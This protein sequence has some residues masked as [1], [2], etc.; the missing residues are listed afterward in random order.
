MSDLIRLAKDL[1][2]PLVGTN[3]LHYTHAHDAKSHAALLCVQSGS[4]LNDPNRFKFDAD[5]FYLKTPQQMRHLF[6]DN[7]EAC[8]N[9]LL[10]AERCNVEFDTAANYMPKFPVPDGETEHSW[11][12][13]EV[14]KGLE[15]RYP[16][17]ITPEV[18][19]RA[20]YEVGIINQMGFPGTSSWSPTSSTGRRTT[21]SAS[22]PA[23]VPVPVRW[24]RT[25][26]A[27]PTSTRSGTV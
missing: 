2:I 25:R 20:D 5:E 18:Q 19:E 27:S 16:E 26:C 14:A 23:V 4:T 11:F 10:I 3:D 21:A 24:W 1:D 22:A 6:R 12:E 7:P 13:K 9:T 15:Y 8:D 17:G